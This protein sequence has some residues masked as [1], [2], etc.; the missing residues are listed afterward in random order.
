MAK[1]GVLFLWVLCWPPRVANATGRLGVAT[2]PRRPGLD[3]NTV[4]ALVES[5]R[6]RAAML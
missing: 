3:E 4:T 5:V 6:S 2:G 1:A